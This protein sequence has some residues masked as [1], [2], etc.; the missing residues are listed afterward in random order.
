MNG[1]ETLAKTYPS[2]VIT[3][4]CD[5]IGNNKFLKKQILDVFRKEGTLFLEN[6]GSTKMISYKPSV[7]EFEK[8][9]GPIKP[10]VMQIECDNPIWE[11][12][13]DII[14]CIYHQEK[15]IS[16]PFTLPAVFS[17]RIN[18]TE[19]INNGDETAFPAICLKLNSVNKTNCVLNI[20]NHTTNKSLAIDCACNK[21]MTIYI[22]TKTRE[23]YTDENDNTLNYLAQGALGDFYLDIGANEIE[24]INNN[25]NVTLDANITYK[26]CYSYGM[27]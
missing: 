4:S 16:S 1:Q 26:C 15:C 12:V 6:E 14:K 10:F 2:R 27:I 8:G 9:Y 13:N 18:K 24:V 7:L 17:L 21:S 19:I 22:N 11:D 23:I 3:I 20:I 5:I 25:P